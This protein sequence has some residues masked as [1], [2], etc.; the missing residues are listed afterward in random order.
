MIIH[1]KVTQVQANGEGPVVVRFTLRINGIGTFSRKLNLLLN[2]VSRL[3]GTQVLAASATREGRLKA[4]ADGFAGR[5][6]G[7]NA[8]AQTSFT[9]SCTPCVEGHFVFHSLIEQK[10][11]RPEARFLVAAS[12]LDGAD[13]R[14]LHALHATGGHVFNLLAF[15]EGLEALALDFLEMREEIFAASRGGDEA[16][17]LAVVKPLHGTDGDVAH[18]VSS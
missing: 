12:D 7:L 1:A 16:E 18:V 9:E 6:S 11:P 4:G 17:T 14:G 3:V 13:A 2:I 5:D 10:K 15:G 8:V